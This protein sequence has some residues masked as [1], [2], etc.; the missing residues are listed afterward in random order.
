MNA[1]EKI[2]DS[3]ISELHKL[4]QDALEVEHATI[5]PYFTAWLSMMEGFN[6]EPKEIVKSV[7]IEE[8]LHLTLVANIMNAVRGIPKL[9]HRD[10]VPRYPHTLP[11]SGD[12][13]KIHIEKFSEKALNTFLHIEKPEVKGILPK[14]EGF[15]TIG[16]FY[17]YV[18]SRIDYLCDTYGEETVFCGK[19]DLQ[20]RPEDYYGS[21]AVVVVKN[22][23]TAHE[24]INIIAEQGEG[25][26]EG[27][28]DADR[29]ILNSGEGKELAHYYRFK[30]ILL[31]RH[32]TK[33]DTPKSGPSGK[34][35]KVDY[36]KVYPLKKDTHRREYPEDSDIRGAL[37]EFANS[38]NQLLVSLEDAFNGNRGRLTE[39]IARMF[40]LRNQGLAIIQTPINNGQRTIGLD[41]TPN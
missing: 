19:I 14:G 13:F 36:D 7:L 34:E 20:I 6:Y 32:Y 41:F 21:G 30:E 1:K 39:G 28:F 12:H 2:R 35:L 18:G 22:R 24:A 31:Q 29:N 17:A 33:N 5:P 40:A 4:L 37:N 3:E 26:H 25:A 16:Q 15:S 10:F 9:T 23:N 8:M 38:Y 27:L 11:H